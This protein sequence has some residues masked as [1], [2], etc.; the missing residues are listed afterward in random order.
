MISAI[1]IYFLTSTP[2]YTIKA[3]K[4]FVPEYLN[5]LYKSQPCAQL[6]PALI[7]ISKEKGMFIANLVSLTKAQKGMF[8]SAAYGA[9]KA[10]INQLGVSTC[11]FIMEST[12]V[13]LRKD[14]ED[15]IKITSGELE[16]QS[17][18]DAQKK[19]ICIYQRP[20]HYEVIHYDINNIDNIKSL[21]DSLVLPDVPEN[22]SWN[23]FA[24]QK[25]N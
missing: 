14:S 5:T 17:H 21:G 25:V 10:I 7:G 18:V 22:E 13:H 20:G 15:Y 8:M 24:D 16:V 11:C 1:D 6:P 19:M 4:E 23:F 2:A 9:S 12:V 3:M